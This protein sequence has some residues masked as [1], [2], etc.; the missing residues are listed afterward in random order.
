MRR[1]AI[2]RYRRELEHAAVPPRVI[3]EAEKAIAILLVL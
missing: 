1:A 3:A 2:K